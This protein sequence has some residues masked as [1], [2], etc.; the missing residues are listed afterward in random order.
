MQ[1]NTEDNEILVK[2]QEDQNQLN[3]SMLQILIDI[4]RR[5]NSGDRTIRLEGSNS[6]TKRRNR[7]PSESSESKGSTGDS[8]SSSQGNER[9]RH[10]KNH[11]HNEFKKEMPPTF[12]GEIKNGQEAESWLLGMRKYFQVQDYSG[13]MKARVSIFNLTRRESIWWEH[14]KKVKKINERNIVWNS[15]R[16]ISRRSTSLKNTMMIRSKSSTS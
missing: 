7:S 4:Q 16:S 11:S 3:E 10:Y 1:T 5:M 2:A 14:F 13:N 15:S 8:S 12:N 9:K 6:S